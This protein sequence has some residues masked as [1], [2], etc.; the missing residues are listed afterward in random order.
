MA[1]PA[2]T[3]PVTGTVSVSVS[4]SVPA[5]ELSGATCWYLACDRYCI[6]ICI[7]ICICTDRGAQW[8]HLLVP[9]LWPVLYLYL[10]LYRQRSSVAPPAGTWPVTS[11]VS[12]SVSVSVPAEELSGATCWYLACDRYW[13]RSPAPQ[14]MLPWGPIALALCLLTLLLCYVYYL[15]CFARK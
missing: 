13:E 4:V 8:R 1:P 10:Y 2:G 3:W 15:L 12:V 7:C 9:G 11:T 5:E 14:R 6:C